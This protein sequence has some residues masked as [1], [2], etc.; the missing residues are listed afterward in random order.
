MRPRDALVVAVQR[1]PTSP[2][3]GVAFRLILARYATTALSSIGSLRTGGRYNMPGRFEALYLAT[4]PLTALLEVEALVQTVE[5]LRGIK[6]PPR[7]LLSVDYRLQAV[8]DLT[9]LPTRQALGTT[10]AELR[11]PWR[12]LNA[13]GEV[14]PTQVL[15]EVVHEHPGIEAL[16]VPSAREPSTDNLVVF[17]DRLQGGSGLRVFDDSGLIDAHLP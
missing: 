11:A 9:E 14:A 5:G 15:G 6:G 13:A 7:I 3:Q 1:L 2:C 16:R 17:P 10:L 12:P 8:A 4:S